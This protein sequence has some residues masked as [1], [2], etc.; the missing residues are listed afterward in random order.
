MG[1]IKNIVLDVLFPRICINCGRQG[2]YICSECD[3][4][5]SESLLICSVCGN[6][7]PSGETHPN[8]LN[9]YSLDGLIS[10]WDYEG[11]IKKLIYQI[12]YD[13]TT[14]IINEFIQKLLFLIIKDKNR[15]SAFLSFLSSEDVYIT[16]VPMYIKRAKRRGFNQSVIIAQ[17]LGK[18]FNRPVKKLLD[19][20][21]DTK[22]QTGLDKEE[23]LLNIKESFGEARPLPRGRASVLLVDDIFTTGATMK[24]CCK[25]LKQ[26][27]VKN[28][29]GFTLA[30]TL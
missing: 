1:R 29:W 28:I 17:E 13:G 6:S 26:S 30:K 27:G 9:K 3:L 18:Y 10:I 23:R 5:L 4:F 11:L 19:K 25:V 24:E 8:C 2:N 21:I 14:D 22:K 15:F 20:I 12:K 7:S 16:Y